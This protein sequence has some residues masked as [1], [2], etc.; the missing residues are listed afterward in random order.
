MS[1]SL[2]TYSVDVPYSDLN[3]F[4]DFIG[5]MGWVAYEK[6]DYPCQMTEIEMRYEVMQSLKD[7]ACGL[8]ITINEARTRH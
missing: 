8:G 7:A 3:F 4:N 2:R 6:N 1:L 5:K